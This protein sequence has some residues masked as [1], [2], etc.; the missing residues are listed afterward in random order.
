VACRAVA[1]GSLPCPP[2][3]RFGAAVFAS[4]RGGSFT[5][6]NVPGAQGTVAIRINNS[7]QI[8]GYY[9]NNN[10]LS[11][12]GFIDTGGSY[13]TLNVPGATKTWAYGVNDAG[14]V[15]GTYLDGSF[16]GADYHG[17]L[18]SGGI[19]TTLDFPAASFTQAWAIN[20]SGQIIGFYSN[21]STTGPSYG[22]LACTDAPCDTSPITIQAPTPLPAALP[23][24]ATGL[25]ALGLFGWR[26]KRKSAA[27]I[28]TA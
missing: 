6:I 19:F 28:A 16:A 17:F 12:G 27:A 23:L 10:G 13:V 2:S 8:V 22:F 4:L 20:D 1:R 7:D 21:N 26:R 5:P 9:A 25:G 11:G 18:Y 15:V 14:Q 3:L 24:F